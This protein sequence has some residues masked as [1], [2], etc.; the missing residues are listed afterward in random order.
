MAR[1]PD[2]IQR[3]IEKAR[4]ALADSLDA[5]GEKASP[6]RFADQGKQAVQS[7]LADPRIKYG[8][9]AVGALVGVA[10]LKKLFS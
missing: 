4:D 2:T 7:K 8:L 6:K 9:I 5:L 3:E 1:D 10:I